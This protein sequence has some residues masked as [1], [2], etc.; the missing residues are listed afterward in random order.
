MKK[1]PQICLLAPFSLSLLFLWVLPCAAVS[2]PSDLVQIMHTT[3]A[4]EPCTGTCQL[5]IPLPNATLANNLL[6]VDFFWRYA[7]TAPS[8]SNIYCNGDSGHATWT[9]TLARSVLNPG[10][11]TDTFSYYVAGA[12]AGCR[13]VTIV[14]SN[15]WVN[16]GATFKEYREIATSSP[17]DATGGGVDSGTSPSFAAS[18][19]TT[20]AG[21][22]V[23]QF[24]TFAPVPG[25]W[26]QSTNGAT[27]SPGFSVLD[28][29]IGYGYGSM[30][31]INSS[32]GT[33]TGTMN[34]NGG[35]S[36]SDGNCTVVAFKT[37]PGA[38]TAASGVHIVQQND[39]T[40]SGTGSPRYEIHMFNAGDALVMVAVSGV[41]FGNNQWGSVSDSLSNL[42]STYVNGDANG[43]Y[44][45]WAVD[46]SANSGDD[47]ISF[48]G[49]ST[50]DWN[51]VFL[52]IAG[53]KNSSHTA[54]YEQ[55]AKVAG[56]GSPY[57]G[58][59]LT[60]STS[61]DLVL[62]MIN[63]GL[64]P[65]TGIGAPTGA[66]YNYPTYT[67][68]TDS[69]D[70][71]EGGGFSI[72]YNAPMSLLTFSWPSPNTATWGASAI[73]L[74]ASSGSTAPSPPTG[75]QAVVH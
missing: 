16:A 2:I 64:G 28:I 44:P 37:S 15:V 42:F 9:W 40:A 70:M 71:T 60:P 24:C 18:V 38:G 68:Q 49:G 17:V 21:D 54:C 59:A 23:D 3:N 67:G 39:Q 56:N 8:V 34:F 10:D 27:A 47:L 72:L 61:N 25:G 51:I 26:P 12:A 57:T 63:E 55:S 4:A 35:A 31:E 50:A 14:A 20:V 5:T 29:E 7:S 65:I 43:W 41:T 74:E 30:A 58:P 13:S 1:I 52:E 48:T 11:S 45:E 36:G 69:S 75:L 66:T 32:T 6:K 73:V 19:A 33:L 46:C 53:L 62:A 22:L